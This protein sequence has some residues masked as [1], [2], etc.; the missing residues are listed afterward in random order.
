MAKG[1]ITSLMTS[2]V[3]FSNSLTKSCHTSYFF[4][5]LE[6][7]AVVLSPPPRSTPSSSSRPRRPLGSTGLVQHGR[8]GTLRLSPQQGAPEANKRSEAG[9]ATVTLWV[10]SVS[11]ASHDSQSSF[12]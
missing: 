9:L 8:D 7:P 1:H 10:C 11:S 2:R 6:S 12:L 4:L 3:F 5:L